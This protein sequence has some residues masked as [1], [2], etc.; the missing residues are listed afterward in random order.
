MT[1]ASDVMATQPPVAAP[2]SPIPAWQRIDVM[3]V[4]RG[5]ALIG[6]LMM[7]I[8]WFNRPIASLGSFDRELI[9]LDYSAGWFV[10][11]FI[12]GKLY[13]LFALLFGMGFA[14]MLLRAQEQGRA[15]AALFT[16]RMAALFLF[17]VLHL[18]LL[19]NGDILHDY[20]VGG[21]A[22]MG[23]LWLLNKPRLQRFNNPTSIMRFSVFMLIAPFIAMTVWGLGYGISVDQSE[24]KTHYEE[25][26]QGFQRYT[27]QVE[28]FKVKPE[29]E[30]WAIIAEHEK[31][32]EADEKNNASEAEKKTNSLTAEQRIEKLVKERYAQRLQQEKEQMEER[33]ALT[34]DSYWDATL[35][36]VKAGLFHLAVTPGFVLL[37][38]LYIFLL[39]Y[40][41]IVSGKMRDTAKHLGFFRALMYIGLG[42]GV[43]LNLSAI[44]LTVHSA[45][46]AADV[47][48]AVAGGLFNLGQYVLCAGYLGAFVVLINSNRWRKL[49]LWLAPL[50][51]MALTNY[52]THSLILSTL[53][54][55]YGFA[56]F[57]HISRGPQMLI[58]VAIIAVQWLFC[59]WWLSRYLY[60][61]MEWV[62]RCIT[63][64]KR[65]PLRIETV[66]TNDIT[67]PSSMNTLS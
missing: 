25:S 43:V 48:Q 47:I 15:F 3:D 31:Q 58:V 7:N 40:W 10:K 60:G 57:G 46:R 65:Q 41:L 23:F 52:L 44:M 22:M 39:G 50:G 64:W 55:G 20:A 1:S 61:P 66:V 9:G 5:F 14:V 6:I 27:K 8:E 62:W 35:H 59:R 19:W 4:L 37:M 13:K 33:T 42:F 21:L 34:S 67:A 24:I 2:L 30:R 56:Q 53:F 49:V 12:E 54:Y 18:F 63:Y 38:L 45:A 29:N 16:R 36:R 17:G 28:E 11:V 51:R 32:Q 26:L